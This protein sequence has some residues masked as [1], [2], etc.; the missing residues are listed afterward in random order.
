MSFMFSTALPSIIKPL[1]APRYSAGMVGRE[2]KTTKTTDPIYYTPMS[3]SQK[4]RRFR[5]I[6][7]QG[8]KPV[9]ILLPFSPLT[10]PNALHHTKTVLNLFKN[11]TT[12]RD[13]W[14]SIKPSSHSRNLSGIFSCVD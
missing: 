7:K 8:W 3:K 5:N 12:Q 9:M 1:N 6:L 14:V 4:K 10:H 2:C 13:V 11:K